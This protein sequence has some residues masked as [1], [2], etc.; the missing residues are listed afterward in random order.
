MTTLTYVMQSELGKMHHHLESHL[1]SSLGSRLEE[2]EAKLDKVLQA[3]VTPR[4]GW[5]WMRLTERSPSPG[6]HVLMPMEAGK[7]PPL[8]KE[9]SKCYG[10]GEPSHFKCECLHSCSP[11]SAPQNQGN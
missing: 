1:E 5:K 7:D 9:A 3:G 8:T 10:C 2:L 6:L 4:E 11:S